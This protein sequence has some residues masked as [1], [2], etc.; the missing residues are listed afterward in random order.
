MAEEAPTP[1]VRQKSSY[2]MLAMWWLPIVSAVV[3]GI[4]SVF[5]YARDQANIQ[6][7]AETNRLFELQRPFL[8]KQLNLYFEIVQVTGLLVT[9]AIQE[10]EWDKHERRF[11][12]LYWAELAMVEAGHIEGIMVQVGEHLKEYRRGQGGPLSD[13]QLLKLKH[14]VYQLAHEVRRAIEIRWHIEAS[15]RP[16]LRCNA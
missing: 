12:Q 10:P 1:E 11:W 4:W 13:N 8:D 16:S 14:C 3:V 2:Q 5:V 6:R 9:T 15:G 7:T